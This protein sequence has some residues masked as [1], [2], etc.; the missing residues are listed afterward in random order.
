MKNTRKDTRITVNY[1]YQHECGSIKASLLL[2]LINT[3]ILNLDGHDK[4]NSTF[5]ELICES[6]FCEQQSVSSNKPYLVGR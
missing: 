5:S 2:K 3:L 4:P 1:K 6:L